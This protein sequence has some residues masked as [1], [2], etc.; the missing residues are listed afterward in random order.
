MSSSDSGNNGAKRG[1]LSA[2]PVY[3]GFILVLLSKS[4]PYGGVIYVGIYVLLGLII[5]TVG[6]LI[7]ILIDRSRA[8]TN[9]FFVYILILIV[10]CSI[11][12]GIIEN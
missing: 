12:L 8:N 9:A 2:I 4:Q 5:Y 7:Y 6:Y 1:I 3:L 10:G 11:G